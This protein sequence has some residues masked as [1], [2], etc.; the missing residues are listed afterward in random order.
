MLTPPI[1][2]QSHGPVRARLRAIRPQLAAAVPPGN[3]G[4]AMMSVNRLAAGLLMLAGVLLLGEATPWRLWAGPVLIWLSCGLFLL[5]HMLLTR[6]FGMLRRSVALLLDAGGVSIMLAAGGEAT[7]FLYV[8]YL[9]VIIGNGFRFGGGYML[10]ASLASIA[11]FI[12]VIA[13][14][15][16]WHDHLGLSLGLLTGLLVLPAYSFALIRQLAAARRQAVRADQAKSLFLASVSHELRTPLNAIIGTAELLQRTA[17]DPEQ[18]ELVATINTAADGQL[19]L[20]QDVLEYSRIE[21]GHGKRTVA[22]FD[23]LEL[24]GAVRTVVAVEARRKGL[25]LNTFVTARTPLRLIGD[26]RHLREVLTNL[27]GNA[28]K[29]TG[30]GSVTLAADGEV[31]SAGTVQLRLEVADTGIGIAPDT[32]GHIFGLFTQANDRILDRF[33]GTGLGL[34]LCERQVRLMG[35]RIEVESQIG[36]G[37]TFAV[38]VALAPGPAMGPDMAPDPAALPAMRVLTASPDPHWSHSMQRRID[39]L[40]VP[41][42]GP[43]VALVQEGADSPPE[44]RGLVEVVDRPVS[45]LP[46]RR[47]RERFAT[48]VDQGCGTEQLAQAVRIAAFQSRIWPASPAGSP[49]GSPDV[50]SHLPCAVSSPPD[51]FQDLAGLRILVADDN[52]IS[53]SV[54]AKVLESAGLRPVFASDGEQALAIL[55]DG[56]V[57]AGLLDVNMPVMDGVEAAQLYRFAAPDGQRVP[58]IA[59]TAD[60]TPETQARCLKAGMAMCLVKPIRAAQLL[61]ALR[62]VVAA[63]PARPASLAPNLAPSSPVPPS[64]VP[65]DLAPTLDPQTLQDLMGLGGFAFVEQLVDEFRHDGSL[66]LAQMESACAMHDVPRFRSDAH[67]MSSVA[68]NMGARAVRARCAPWQ[69]IAEA[70][71]GHNGPHLLDTLRD[72][73]AKTCADLD[74]FLRDKRSLPS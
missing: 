34:A 65:A 29:F 24:L 6:R 53:R 73:W 11:G 8:V 68:A 38:C 41:S 61:D 20:V 31:T 17:L 48:A 54:L 16:F 63:W 23:L 5:V 25:L 69:T 12:T 40:P 21:A 60:G 18:A 9:W 26:E 2:P 58:L 49:A 70:E 3:G 71:L 13:Y 35:G 72:D 37:S 46:G 67:S 62:G 30:A 27:C 66:L 64:R 59:L 42:D 22:S 15:P 74:R 47:T 32:Q 14:V 36:L 56:Q 51:L 28:V 1:V 57:D 50:A 52:G 33:G 43:A 4:E 45:G 55:S 19:S 44:I 39:A 10:A 7:A